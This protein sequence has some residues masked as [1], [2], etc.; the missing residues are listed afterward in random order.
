MIY[1]TAGLAEGESRDD[2]RQAGCGGREKQQEE[3]LLSA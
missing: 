1:R 2:A 3:A